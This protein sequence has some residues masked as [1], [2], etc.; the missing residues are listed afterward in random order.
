MANQGDQNGGNANDNSNGQ[1]A[2]G[3]PSEGGNE[4]G[5]GVFGVGLGVAAEI[6][7]LGFGNLLSGGNLQGLPSPDPMVGASFGG[8]NTGADLGINA[9][10]NSNNRSGAHGG[11][12]GS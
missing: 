7:G 12:G 4:V 5:A 11:G 3:N 9:G 8:Y 1:Q 2:G 10:A 6:A